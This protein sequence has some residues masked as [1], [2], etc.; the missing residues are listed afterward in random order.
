[1]ALNVMRKTDIPTLIGKQF[2]DYTIRNSFRSEGAY[3]IGMRCCVCGADKVVR[4]CNFHSFSFRCKHKGG[5]YN[6]DCKQ[7]HEVDV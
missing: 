2:G 7:T 6:V 1:M 5:F 3:Y 4:L